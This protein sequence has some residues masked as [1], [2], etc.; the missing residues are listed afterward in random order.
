MNKYLEIILTISTFWTSL[1][2]SQDPKILW[3][4]DTKSF[5]AGQAACDDLDGDG[6][7]EI[8]FGCYRN[9]GALY[10]LNAEDGSLL[11]KYSP[12]NPEFE[13][14]NDVALL[15]YD[16]VGDQSK[17]V[18]L[19]SSC[20]P[21]TTCL[22]GKTGEVIWQ[23]QTGGSDSPPTIADIDND[24]SLEILHG[25]FL[26]WVRCLDAKT[27]KLKWRILVANNSWIQTAPSIV[28]LNNDNNLDWVVGTWHFDK[29]DSLY[30]FDGK[31]QKRLW[32]LPVHGN[33][34]HGTSVTDLDN[35]TKPELLFGSYNKKV[36]C[37]NGEDGSIDWT[38]EG[39]SS[40]SCPISIGD[41]DSDGKCDILFTSSYE[42]IA[43]NSDGKLKWKY[44]TPDNS[45][46]F[47]GITLA[48]VN[49]DIYLDCIFGTYSGKLIVL[50][51]K[52]GKEYQKID[53]LADYGK[54]PFDINHQA[55]VAD[56]N[57]DGILDAFVVGG[58][59]EYPSIEK[60][61][62]R[63]YMVSLGK[64]NGPVW[65]MFQQ[66]VRRHSTLCNSVITSID[67]ISENDIFLQPNPSSDFIELK[68]SDNS[69]FHSRIEV[70]NLVGA[71]YS[72]SIVIERSS[73]TKSIKLDISNLAP[74]VY[75]LR[76]NQSLYKFIKI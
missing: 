30:A 41:V 5:A 36:Y 28:D 55:L 33:I 53:L 45:F 58:Y 14:C 19:A 67:P 37:V 68:L 17:E 15:I 59:G 26:G 71:N 13:G 21:V 66:D 2:V 35:D 1:L 69:S 11:W 31:T 20:T 6:K 73:Y 72:N 18:I 46:S 75:L 9:D 57:Q 50:N 74:G 27:G 24:G 7:Y 8:A 62:G 70:I 48:D 44:N 32:T 61:Y 63:A 12:H 64:G 23:A 25:E 42:A 39:L 34:Y 3:R 51:G 16:V 4:F 40:V 60:G 10:V 56:F 52:D 54:S 29:K 43:L 38:Y 47:R 22:N 65:T 76:S 49:N